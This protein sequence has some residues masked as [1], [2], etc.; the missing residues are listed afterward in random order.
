MESIQL[1]RFY[2]IGPSPDLI[3]I[4]LSNCN[5]DIIE[6]YNK[7]FSCEFY[8]N[9]KQLFSTID[10][11]FE[12]NPKGTFLNINSTYFIQ[13]KISDTFFNESVVKDEIKVVLRNDFDNEIILEKCF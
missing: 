13:N 6:S 10:C 5:E 3:T 4:K 12:V 1:E 2:E 9:E 11:G 7:S 8:N